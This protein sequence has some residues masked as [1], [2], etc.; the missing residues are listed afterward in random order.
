MSKLAG[1]SA[2]PKDKEQIIERVAAQIGA[3]EE[4]IELGPIY[5]EALVV[6]VISAQPI[7]GSDHL[8]L[9][10]IDDKRAFSGDVERSTEGFV[11][12]VCG[13]PNVRAGMNAVWLPPGSI[14]PSSLST[15][16]PFKLSSRKI[17]DK[18]SNGMLASA[19]ELAI[20][21][22]HDG[23][24]ELPDE[25]AYGIKLADVIDLNDTII[26]IENKMFTHR[27]D[28]FG[29][30]GIARE[31][32]AVFG[33][34][35]K[36]PDWYKQDNLLTS[37]KS[38]VL[39]VDNRLVDTACKRFS[40]VAIDGIRIEPSPLWLQSYLARSG[41]RPLNNIVDITNYVMLITGQ[42]LHA[43]DFN[44]I[45]SG[46]KAE[47]VVRDATEGERL[48][49]L[50]GS[51]V[52]LS[53]ADIVI[54]SGDKAIGLG[55]VMG[56]RDSEVSNATTSII[57][58]C[59]NFDM[60]RIRRSSMEHGI[61]SEA[62]TRFNKGQSP[63]QCPCVLEY[64]F[65]LIKQL[66]PESELLS[67]VV[68]IKSSK[69]LDQP[70]EVSLDLDQLKSYL[71]QQ[72]SPESI[73]SLLQNAELKARI[74]GNT[75]YVI[76]P[77]WRTDLAEAVDLIEEIARL[78]GFDNLSIDLPKSPLKPPLLFDLG[79]MKS[80][81]RHA[82]AAA[83]AN[84]VLTYSFVNQALLE[85]AKQDKSKAYK[86]SNAL[87]PELEY[88]RLSL[89]PSLLSK[90]HLNHKAGYG[91]FCLF[92]IGKA[93]Q[94]G[95]LDEEGLPQEAER[96]AVVVSADP[97]S[98]K[99]FYQGEAFYQARA[100]LDY[101]LGALNCT[102]EAMGENIEF[103]PE[104]AAEG[105]APL[106]QS[107][108][109]TYHPG[110]SAVMVVHGEVLGVLGEFSTETA[111]ALKLPAFCA[112]FELDTTLLKQLAHSGAN[113]AA[114]SKYPKIAQDLTLSMHGANYAAVMSALK[115]KLTK[116]LPPDVSFKITPIDAFSKDD[117][118]D[119]VNWTF[120]IEFSS[121]ER[122]LTDKEISD[123]LAKVN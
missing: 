106:W 117:S 76:P 44:K 91:R 116:L 114:P 95:I 86:I 35:F 6:R 97:K 53:S 41:I 71:N 99:A 3:I 45:A 63:Y 17:M 12:V 77:F 54:A 30:L 50:D 87:S 27:P 81:I 10:Q 29:Q 66:C 88:Y 23:I 40:A 9:C 103:L 80:D 56:G 104:K 78:H 20:S 65:S 2:F 110:R 7:S 100:Y 15:Q 46:P 21:Q 84:E 13:A 19:H 90:V 85:A 43:Y 57:L 64:A 115:E 60:Y 72:L 102:F 98:A 52:P 92:E 89:V 119:S 55:G 4:V 26:D 123:T 121:Y 83:G 108:L 48:G 49:L 59:A 51:E 96:L 111:R 113:Y 47:L 36:S 38:G 107:A 120:H 39:S 122:T 24:V 101:L 75:L 93:H 105:L 74:D 31:I 25:S 109:A 67:E 68:D 82:L 58:E 61:F 42:P 79:T 32:C 22:D 62:V 37:D 70:Q 1:A 69:L 28:L 34:P 33:I 16:E 118:P 8:S 112:G 73:I 18:I 11:Q 5:Q 94:V 14:V